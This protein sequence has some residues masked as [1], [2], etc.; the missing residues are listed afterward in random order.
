MSSSLV[1]K[2]AAKAAALPDEQ[3]QAALDYIESLEREAEKRAAPQRKSLMGAFAHL[4]LDVTAEDIDEVRREMWRNF[5]REEP[6]S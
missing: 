5:P 1:E 3:Q 4:G 2:I 6:R